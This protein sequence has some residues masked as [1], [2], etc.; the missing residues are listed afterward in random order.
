MVHQCSTSGKQVRSDGGSE[1]I[2]ATSGGGL[3]VK[4]EGEREAE[5]GGV[6]LTLALS[7]Y[8]LT[9]CKVRAKVPWERVLKRGKA[10][11]ADTVFSGARYIWDRGLGFSPEAAPSWDADALFQMDK[12]P[13]GMRENRD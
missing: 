3:G 7:L 2:G 11:Q 5:V 1:A 9:Y 4:V 8:Q 12:A 10:G 13:A 6:P